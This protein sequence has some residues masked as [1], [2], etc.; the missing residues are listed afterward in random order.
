VSVAAAFLM[1]GKSKRGLD[2]IPPTA[3]DLT[4][5]EMVGIHQAARAWF[6]R[7]PVSDPTVVEMA[8]MPDHVTVALRPFVNMEI[9]LDTD[10]TF[11]N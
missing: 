8:G 2:F 3:Q 9:A 11:G 4:V 10:G 1:G 7:S 6:Q 5:Y